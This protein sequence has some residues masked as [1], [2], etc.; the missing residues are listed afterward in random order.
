MLSGDLVSNHL[1]HLYT[2]KG[3]YEAE[4][5]IHLAKRSLSTSAAEGGTN[6]FLFEYLFCWIDKVSG[7][8]IFFLTQSTK[9]I[10]SSTS[11]SPNQSIFYPCHGR[12]LWWVVGVC[13][14]Y[15]WV[16]VS[17]N[18]DRCATSADSKE[19]AQKERW[20][21]QPRVLGCLD[22]RW[23]LKSGGMF[24]NWATRCTNTA[25]VLFLFHRCRINCAIYEI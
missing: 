3:S 2:Q 16:L 25:R 8:T 7:R 12:T 11:Q 15:V 1:I 24:I 10:V 21:A 6:P 9:D 19:L 4:D 23:R 18:L 13:L 17:A 14:I 5:S 22:C 20:G